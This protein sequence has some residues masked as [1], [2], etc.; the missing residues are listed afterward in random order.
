MCVLNWRIN[1]GLFG[2]RFK[3]RGIH[4]IVFY[5]LPRYPQFYSEICNMLQDNRKQ[6]D[7][8]NLTCTVM[9]SSFDAQRLADIVGT[10]RAA[11]MISSSKK[12][13]MFVTG[14]NSWYWWMGTSSWSWWMENYSKSKLIFMLQSKVG[15]FVERH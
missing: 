8:E 4:H 7:K 6:T 11:R 13:H 10:D 14:E 2:Y 12:V 15:V 1:E 3:L 5:E 9:Y